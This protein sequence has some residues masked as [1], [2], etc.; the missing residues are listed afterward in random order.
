LYEEERLKQRLR[1][2]LEDYLELG[3][4]EGP[5]EYMDKGD[6]KT[7]SLLSYIDII[8]ISEAEN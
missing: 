3:E 1:K 8:P 5:L 7:Q 2:I 4:I 6:T